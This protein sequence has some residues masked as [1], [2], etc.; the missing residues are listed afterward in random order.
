MAPAKLSALLLRVHL[1]ALLHIVL[2][3]FSSFEPAVVRYFTL[4]VLCTYVTIFAILFAF[5]H[6]R[7]SVLLVAVKALNAVLMVEAR[8]IFFVTDANLLT[9]SALALTGDG[10]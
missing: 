10:A 6:K 5:R 8:I 3:I 7:P 2:P 9:I 1:H 4:I